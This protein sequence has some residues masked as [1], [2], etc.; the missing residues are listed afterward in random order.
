L[1]PEGN[2]QLEKCRHR[3]KDNIKT[4]LN[5]M[6]GKIWSGSIWLRIEASDGFF[7]LTFMYH[8]IRVIYGLDEKP[9]A[10]EEGFF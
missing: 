7:A 9:L 5:E 6:F 1:H 10:V 3:W 8:K 2:R 4:Y